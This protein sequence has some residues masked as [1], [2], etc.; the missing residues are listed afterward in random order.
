[1]VS[2]RLD[3]VLSE[4]NLHAID[5]ADI[6][7]A[8]HAALFACARLALDKEVV[9]LQRIVLQETGKSCDLARTMYE[10]GMLRNVKTLADWLRTQQK[11]GLLKLENAEE[12]AGILLGMVVLIPQR[13]AVFGGEP[14]PSQEQISA[15]VRT[16]VSL[17]LRGCQPA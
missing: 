9:T 6:D 10:K 14:L 7:E 11:R 1:M 3:R 12:A 8:L 4:V 13:A 2:D 17:F 16:C 15:R 5:H